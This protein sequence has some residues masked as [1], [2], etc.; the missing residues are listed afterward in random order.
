MRGLLF[1]GLLLSL[2]FSISWNPE[3]QQF[4]SRAITL[5]SGERALASET[6][7]LQSFDLAK[8]D[9]NQKGLKVFYELDATGDQKRVRYYVE[10]NSPDTCSDCIGLGLAHSE[11]LKDQNVKNVELLNRMIGE[12]AISKIS[13][14]KV[15]VKEPI[16]VIS[17]VKKSALETVTSACEDE[18]SVKMTA[19]EKALLNYAIADGSTD[20]DGRLTC[21]TEEF[22]AL[23]DECQ[24]TLDGST[25]GL[26]KQEL[27]DSLTARKACVAKIATYYNKFLKKDLAEGLSAK[28][29]AEQNALTATFR[30]GILRNIPK[31]LVGLKNDIVKVSQT[32]LL[33]RTKIYY[34]NRMASKAT[35]ETSE[36]IAN[37]AKM[38]MVT[39]LHGSQ[40]AN[41]CAAYSGLSAE[42]C[43]AGNK[44]PVARA[45]FA[46]QSSAY[47]SF[48]QNFLSPLEKFALSPVAVD[49]GFDKL[50]DPNLA[51]IPAPEGMYGARL[52]L[53]SRGGNSNL[54]L[55][56][57]GSQGQILLP[58]QSIQQQVQAVP[59]STVNQGIIQAPMIQA[60]AANAYPTTQGQLAPRVLPVMKA[61]VGP[62][63]QTNSPAIRR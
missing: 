56:T 12:M 32:G 47:N 53:Q 30:D 45:A 41:F 21:K 59:Q 40:N 29:S 55:P 22:Q 7:I 63:I 57:P 23:T 27:K 43:M 10:G 31:V 14:K 35:N 15:E 25:G 8:I 24:E 2:G 36:S 50:I 37:E 28:A 44:N 42:S 26:S 9:P 52:N 3:F 51:K 38:K 60:P 58:Q 6:G 16:K 18:D 11:P 62:T 54:L 46:S 49:G 61:P 34:Q 19:E 33:D 1:S 5:T 48:N 39:E 4:G 20:L 17:D 13:R